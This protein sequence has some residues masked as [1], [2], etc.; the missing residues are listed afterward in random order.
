MWTTFWR[1]LPRLISPNLPFSLEHVDPHV[2]HKCLGPP[3]SPCNPNNLFWTF[4][5]RIVMSRIF[6]YR[7]FHPA[8]LCRFS[9]LTFSTLEF[10]MNKV[11][12]FGVVFSCFAFSCLTFSAS[13]KGRVMECVCN[14]ITMRCACNGN[15]MINIS[16]YTHRDLHT[17]GEVTYLREYQFL[18]LLFV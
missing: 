18:N 11:D 15:S 4:L 14:G 1:F 8:V 16:N 12:Q 2:I 10:S 6:K 5:S 3:H 17:G 9:C 7:I 13:P